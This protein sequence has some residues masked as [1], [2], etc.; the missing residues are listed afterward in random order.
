MYSYLLAKSNASMIT[1]LSFEWTDDD[2]TSL[3]VSWDP[4]TAPQG[5]VTYRISYSPFSAKVVVTNETEDLSILLA[6]LHPD[7]FY[8]VMVDAI[9]QDAPTTSIN[10]GKYV[11]KDI[12][13]TEF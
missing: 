1:G 2:F 4:V 9:I 6:G 11:M 3:Q 7:L 12:R 13:L 10:T 5:R 8:S